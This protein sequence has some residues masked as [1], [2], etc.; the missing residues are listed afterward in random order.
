MPE[1]SKAANA[2]A[3]HVVVIGGGWAG[4][5]AAKTLCEAGVRVTLVDGMPDHTG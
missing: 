4:W 5:G 2:D 1:L 3:S